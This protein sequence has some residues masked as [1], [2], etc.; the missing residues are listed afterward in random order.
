[1]LVECCPYLD[2]VI[3]S[4]QAAV[5]Q[6][7]PAIN[8]ARRAS[9]PSE[10]V[11]LRQDG[12]GETEMPH[13]SR[14][15]SG[16]ASGSNANE[17]PSAQHTESNAHDGDVPESNGGVG[18]GGG[19][20][21][22]SDG[23]VRPCGTVAPSTKDEDDGGRAERRRKDSG[24][25]DADKNPV[26]EISSSGGSTITVLSQ[27]SRRGE[28]FLEPLGDAAAMLLVAIEAVT[29]P[30]RK[31]SKSGDGEAVDQPNNA[32]AQGQNN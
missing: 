13:K 12:V 23:G 3:P 2:S 6:P 1:M 32:N 5:S 19:G 4:T 24:A 31:K 15:E 14:N 28:E 21:G 30:V 29:S 27:R 8:S 16:E 11:D 22:G 17:A 10:V 26:E 9:P 18:V 25:A 7:A 20:G